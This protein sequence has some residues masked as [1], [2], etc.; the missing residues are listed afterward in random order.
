MDAAVKV[1]LSLK[2][3]YKTLTGTDFPTAGRNQ[4][5]KAPA[6]PKEKSKPKPQPKEKES[7]VMNMSHAL[8]IFMEAKI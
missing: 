6:Q 5:K 3:E 1:L 4:N 2:A 7:E 8:F